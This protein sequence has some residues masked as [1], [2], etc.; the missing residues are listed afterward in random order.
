MIESGH[1]TERSGLPSCLASVR[2]AKK[3]GIVWCCMWLLSSVGWAQAEQLFPA[4]NTV[5]DT[6]QEEDLPADLKPDFRPSAPALERRDRWQSF[7]REG[8]YS[9]P[10]PQPSWDVGP[11][12][13]LLGSPALPIL[14]GNIQEQEKGGKVTDATTKKK[15]TGEGEQADIS[16]LSARDLVALRF[17]EEGEGILED[18]EI[19]RARVLFEQAIELAPVQPYSYHFLGRIAYSEG[20]LRESLAFLHK[21][22]ILFDRKNKEWLGETTCLRGLIAEDLE[23]FDEA[24]SAY[25]RCLHYTPTNLRAVTALARLSEAKAEF[26]SYLPAPQMNVFHARPEDSRNRDVLR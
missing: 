23:D 9:H 25:E 3:L 10:F 1:N 21:A 19:E 8:F 7:P 14:N 15:K 16:A 12:P 20:K 6:I 17:V 4:A 5:A 13:T 26:P 24:R 22:E 2:G 11:P 18:G